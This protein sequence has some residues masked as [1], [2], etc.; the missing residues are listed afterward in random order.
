MAQS[1]VTYEQLL[2]KLDI[3][4]PHVVILG[5]GASRAACLAGDKNGKVLPLM[6]DFIESIGLEKILKQHGINENIEDFERFYSKINKDSNFTS[7]ISE[8]EDHIKDYFLSLELPDNPTIY[9]HLVLSLREKDMIATFNWDPLLIQAIE[10]NRHI[11]NPPGLLFLHGNVGVGFCLNDCIKGVVDGLCPEC[12]EPYQPMKLF[13]PI[14]EKDYSKDPF[15]AREWEGVKLSVNQGFMLTIF[16]YSAPKADTEAVT[17]LRTAWTE[18]KSREFVQ[19]EII[20]TKTRD[21]L[22]ESWGGF[23]YSHHY[24]TFSSFYESWIARHPRRTCEAMVMP[25]RYGFFVDDFLIPK[26]YNFEQ[27]YEWLKPL[28]DAENEAEK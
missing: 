6:Q 19:T 20:D 24:Q 27:L 23:T 18:H 10:R 11:A 3:Q 26:E 5:A 4:A 1:S 17:L 7:L 12:Y 21:K 14:E 28:L 22:M 2:T 9:D 16:G 13:F 15:I 25:T 8:L